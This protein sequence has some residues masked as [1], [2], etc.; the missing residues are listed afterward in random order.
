MDKLQRNG[1][2]NRT[3]LIPKR[4]TTLNSINNVLQPNTLKTNRTVTSEL[5]NQHHKNRIQNIN[6]GNNSVNRGWGNKG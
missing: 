1:L 4:N 3:P 5:Y 6:N 2:G